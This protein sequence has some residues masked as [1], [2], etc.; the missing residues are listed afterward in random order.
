[1]LDSV[2]EKVVLEI[3]TA[4]EEALNAPQPDPEELYTDVYVSY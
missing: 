3:K 2:H 4:V 1:M